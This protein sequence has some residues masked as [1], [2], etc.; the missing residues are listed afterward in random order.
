MLRNGSRCIVVTGIGLVTPLGLTAEATFQN[1]I[2]GKS[3]LKPLD[4]A[5]FFLPNYISEDNKIPTA[6]KAA[7]LA[8]LV[9]AMP[10]K[11]VGPVVEAGES[12]D[13]YDCEGPERAARRRGLRFAPT[14]H[15]PRGFRF[16]AAA[17]EEALRDALL[18][19]RPDVT[20]GSP[21]PPPKAADN[22]AAS[23]LIG[24]ADPR[25]VG[26]N[27][28]MGI[29]S[30]SDVADV[31]ASLTG[32]LKPAGG[33][34]YYSRINPFFVPKIL[35]NMAAGATA[36][37]YNCQGFVSSSVAACATGAHCI[38]ESFLFMRQQSPTQGGRATLAAFDTFIGR[39]SESR[40]EESS[41]APADGSVDVMICGAT[42]ACITPVSIGGFSRM[43]A[44]STKCNEGTDDG[45]EG[46]DDGNDGGPATASRPFEASRDGFVMS[47]GAGILILEE[48]EHARRRIAAY[49]AAIASD[50]T[51][52]PAVRAR[53]ASA[54]VGD[55][56]YGEVKGFGVSCDAHHV[57]APHPAGRG[58]EACLRNC[59]A[60]GGVFKDGRT[61]N[62][63][64][65]AESIEGGQADFAVAAASGSDAATSTEA[66]AFRPLRIGYV[67]AHATGTIGDDI[68]LGAIRRVFG[69]DTHAAMG[70]AST[71]EAAT[72]P[73][74]QPPLYVSSTKGGLGHLLG[75]AGSVEA[76]VAL[77][78][79]RAQTAPPTVNLRTPCLPAAEQAAEGICLNAAAAPLEGCA[80]VMSTSF[81]FGGINTALLFTKVTEVHQQGG[82][83]GR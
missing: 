36:I 35:G 16:C 71:A 68:E 12:E 48:Y 37:R 32:D 22:G 78:A 63:F 39:P 40:S 54:R 44:L 52:D 47:E 11:V 67:N 29:P 5:P 56:I 45:N 38:G 1:L 73:R 46:T 18:L 65:A 66:C 2:D 51:V 31:T 60:S 25:R 8:E 62:T 26:V 77:L 17:V 76:A 21:P 27:I 74:P 75:A 55:F 15:E 81:G 41:G 30:L 10:C 13:Y 72:V 6:D 83:G 82:G 9:R 80:A 53:Y 14:A 7:M 42:E 79:L 69:A 43:R 20:N 59:L 49:L 64:Y 34:V 33:R 4:K 3:G 50:A 28:G 24:I 58:A 19:H 70:A 57:A 61:A 23:P